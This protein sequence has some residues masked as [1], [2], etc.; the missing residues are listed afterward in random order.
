[1]KNPSRRY[2]AGGSRRRFLKGAAALGLT[3]GAITGA[4]GASALVVTVKE[5][6]SVTSDATP[7]AAQWVSPSEFVASSIETG[8]I[9]YVVAWGGG[10]YGYAYTYALSGA[11]TGVVVDSDTG[12]LSIGDAL[13]L[14]VYN[15]TVSVTNRVATSNSASFPVTLTVLQGVTSGRTGSQILHKTYIPGAPAGSDYTT[16]LNTMQATILADQTAAGD[17]N[18]RATILFRRGVTYQY[19]NNH[20]LTGIQFYQVR[21]DP[22]SFGELPILQC[23]QSGP[24]VYDN[25]PLNI[26]KGNAVD[27]QGE[28]KALC[29]NLNDVALGSTVVTLTSPGDASKIVPDRWHV[30]MS[31]CNQL[32]GYPPNVKHLDY[33]KVVSVAGSSVTLDRPTKYKHSAT[34]WEDPADDL[35][36]GRA[37]LVPWDLGGIGGAVPS[38]PR[39]TQRGNFTNLHFVA[40]PNGNDITYIESH[41]DL[42]F[43]GCVFPDP[44]ITM[45]QHVLIHN[46]AVTGGEMD[47]MME[48]VIFDGGTTTEMAGGSGAQY[49]LSRNVRHGCMQIGPRQF[50][51]IGTTIDATG[52]TY[53]DVPISFAYNGPT[54]YADFEAT[55]IKPF[56]PNTKLWTWSNPPFSPIR[57]GIDASWNGN[58][59]IIPALFARFQ[60]WLVA[61]YEGMII[62]TTGAA[63]II[64]SWGYINNLTGPGDGS[65]IWAD[66]VWV[67]GTKPTSGNIYPNGRFRE[68]RISNDSVIVAPGQWND[69]GFMKETIPPQFG[70]SYDFPAAYPLQYS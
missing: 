48:T 21:D 46:C 42:S 66:I 60:D 7:V 11:P 6:G 3:F 35:S 50:R 32:G 47:K 13:A 28:V 54:M 31:E 58:R 53:L 10:E 43:D 68:L 22:A 9:G 67:A 57:L 70:P 36:F 30:I 20:W 16:A 55:T 51:S 44:Q 4:R 5:D 33:V 62:S 49:W 37:R 23:T 61:I 8:R 39:L 19:T 14:G 38:D 15:F 25:G 69:P 40:N 17:G 56:S 63:P 24:S 65:A 52:D 1:M 59:L 12:I 29:A 2:R 18:L 26:G 41:L 64:L 45:S 34:A 27:H